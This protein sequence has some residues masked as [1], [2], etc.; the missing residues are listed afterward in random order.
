[1]TTIRKTVWLARDYE[2]IM[3]RREPSIDSMSGDW[4]SKGPE[5]SI[6]NET[7]RGLFG[8]CAGLK[9]MRKGRYVLML[10][11]VEEE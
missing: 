5:L 9:K 7:F 3:T 8:N 4:G 11:P 6:P 1:M 10:T 2:F